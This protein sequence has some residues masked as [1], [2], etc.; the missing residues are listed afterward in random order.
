MVMRLVNARIVR[1]E[2]VEPGEIFIRGGVLAEDGPADAPLLDCE[3]DFLLP[4]L[5]DLHTDGIEHHLNPRPGVRWPSV[6][7]AVLSHDWE[8]LGAGITTVLDA[9]S[10][11][12]YDSAGQRTALL[13]AAITG[14]TEARAAGLLRVD[15]YFHFRCELSDASLLPLVA[16][17]IDNGSLRLASLM[18]H[19]PGQRQWHDLALFRE[20]RRKKNAR[21]WTDDEF[22]LYLAERQAHQRRFVPPGRIRIGELCRARGI[23]LASHDDTTSA[24][25]EESDRHGASISEFPTTLTAARRARELGMTIVMGAPNIV[26]GGS[27]SGNVGAAELADADLLDVLTSDYVPGSLLQAVFTLAARGL[28]LP[29]TVAMASASPARLLGFSDRGRIA[30][31]L[32]ADLLRVRLAGG[33]PVIRNIWV[34]GRRY[35]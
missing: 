17:H 32:R 10:L 1:P 20:F 27:H 6:L 26:L 7:A 8:L 22:E 35:L 14:L 16:R 23:P 28:D 4:G 18:D 34:A 21:V 29:R 3:G 11:G 31:G 5:I 33:V 19:T 13:D 30:P 15:H 24:D 2:A 9:L 25:V 12:D